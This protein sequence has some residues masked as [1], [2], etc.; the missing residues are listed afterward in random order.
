MKYIVILYLFFSLGFFI[1]GTGQEIPNFLEKLTT[2]EGLSSNTIT[3]IVQDDLGFLWIATSD[4]LN[5]YD[6]TGVTQFYHLN[7]P[8]SIPHNHVYCLKKL[9]Q[10]YQN[11]RRV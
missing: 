10:N 2:E 8:N 1:D 9:Q 3:D 4:G 7:N 5:R 6:G 11:I